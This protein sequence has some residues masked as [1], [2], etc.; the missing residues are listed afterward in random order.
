MK[1]NPLALCALLIFTGPPPGHAQEQKRGGILWDT[2]GPR[3]D[4]NKDGRITREEF[5]GPAPMFERFD[6]NK[7]GVL[8]KEE[9]AQ[10][11][12]G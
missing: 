12:G 9:H 11:S 2:L 5:K 3:Y 8:T 7:D 6:L 10:A 1:T 4:A